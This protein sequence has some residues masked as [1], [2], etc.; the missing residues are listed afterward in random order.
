VDTSALKK[1]PSKKRKANKSK[2][3]QELELADLIRNGVFGG[4]YA[5][6]VDLISVKI[7]TQLSRQSDRNICRVNFPKGI[8]N[9]AKTTASEQQGLTFL[10][11]II[12]CSSWAL[13]TEGL[14]PRLGDARIGGYISI[15]ESL[16]CLEE[17]LKIHPGKS[18]RS[19]MTSDIPAV[20]YYTRVVL[21][22]ITKVA[23]RTV[24]DGFNLIKFHLN[25]HMIAEDIMKYG[26]PR[27]I[28]GGPGESQ[29]KENFKNP[30]E[31]T[32]KRENVFDEQVA[33][34]HHEHVT[35]GKCVE[36]ISRLNNLPSTTTT[37][38][39]L[40]SHDGNPNHF[41]GAL[42]QSASGVRDLNVNERNHV[43]TEGVYSVQRVRKST[44][45]EVSE[46]EVAIVFC[47]KKGSTRA[48]HFPILPESEYMSSAEQQTFLL[49]TN[50][51]PAGTRGL[52]TLNNFNDSFAELLDFL[53]PMFANGKGEDLQIPLYTKLKFRQGSCDTYRA[54][55]FSHIGLEERQ[56]WALFQWEDWGEVPGQILG[57]L[58]MTSDDVIIYN[59]T[60]EN[61]DQTIS[62]GPGQYA[63]VHSLEDSI[64]GLMDPNMLELDP[65]HVMQANSV[66]LF[67]GKKELCEKGKPAVRL[68]DVACIVRPLLV[69]PDFDPTF[70]SDWKHGVNVLE[71][72]TSDKRKYSY[73]IVRPRDQWHL[74]FLALAHNKYGKHVEVER[75]KRN[76]REKRSAA[77]HAKKAQT[78]ECP[79]LEHNNEK[80]D[81]SCDDETSELELVNIDESSDSDLHCNI[82]DGI[83]IDDVQD[84]EEECVDGRN[85]EDID[86]TGMEEDDQYGSDDSSLY[87]HLV[88]GYA[89]RDENDQSDQNDQSNDEDEEDEQEDNV[90]SQQGDSQDEGDELDDDE[91]S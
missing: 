8:M 58:D 36:R 38:K 83:D 30:A 82:E 27:N 44:Q 9:R 71:W 1:I 6:K 57:F 68:I 65:A 41:G 7:G 40:L 59:Q 67:Y 63:I 75:K 81:D 78:A 51:K 45:T 21:D 10:M 69:I 50:G 16:L 18:E 84:D 23:D 5:R 2:T 70:D 73:T 12:L 25:I 90:N 42:K 17:L 91:E 26:L 79:E 54:D 15:M 34:R 48:G 53:K 32:Q 77:A 4:D 85:R 52:G 47:G 3:A 31:T 46:F 76:G 55:P 24:G 74:V 20:S 22:K 80:E 60:R 43:L 49:G 19:W 66:L 89:C 56:D 29:F 86:T 37:T 72:V 88:D 35:I 87:D 62:P 28:S 13:Q 14:H 39:E 64:P 11:N 61:V 33:E